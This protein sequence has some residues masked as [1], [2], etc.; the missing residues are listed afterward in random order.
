MDNF[1]KYPHFHTDDAISTYY[2]FVN[3]SGIFTKLSNIASS[4]MTRIA[5][6]LGTL[7]KNSGGISV[8]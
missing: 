1:K 3:N 6:K 2:Y 4:V 7:T 5:A 8:Y